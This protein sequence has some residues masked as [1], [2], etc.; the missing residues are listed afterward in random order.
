MKAIFE[1]DLHKHSSDLF[2]DIDEKPIASASLAQVHRAKLA[3]T[4]QDVAIKL[5]YPFLMIQSKWD[6]IMLKKLT[7]FCN[8]LIRKRK[9]NEFDFIKLY[10]EWT[11]TLV[12]ELDFSIEVKN[13]L[14]TKKLFEGNDRIYIPHYYTELC[15]DRLI[16]MEY[17]EGIKVNQ[18][19]L[20]KMKGIDTKLVAKNLLNI[21]TTMIFKHGFVHCDAHPGN[22]LI[23]SKNNSV[24]HE[25]VLLDHGLY[26]S[27]RPETI[28][29]FSGLFL[30]LMLQ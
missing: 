29:N 15:S 21:F 9:N 17:V 28:Y 30:S 25:I 4:N 14:K 3:G 18:A 27:L 8:Y 24:G 23:R 7:Q 1:S 26:R 5:Q 10:D 2:I 6:L 20:M 22:F 19:E 12:E 16:V 13:A 11:S